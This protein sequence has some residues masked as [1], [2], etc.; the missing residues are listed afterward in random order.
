MRSPFDHDVG[1]LSIAHSKRS[2]LIKNVLIPIGSFLVAALGLL[3]KDTPAWVTSIVI[4]YLVFVVAITFVPVVWGVFEEW[5]C[6]RNTANAIKNNISELEKVVDKLSPQLSQSRSGAIFDVWQ[7]V[8]AEKDVKG[9][10]Y[11]DSLHL[12][13]LN[14]WF[15]LIR[16][17][18]NVVKK[19]DRVRLI[20]EFSSLVFQYARFCEQAYRDIESA[21]AVGTMDDKKV[22]KIKQEWNHARDSH[23]RLIE[24]WTDICAEINRL[25]G[26][27]ILSTYFPMLKPF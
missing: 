22:N 3:A 12:D 26:K 21:I 5:I 17:Y 16:D 24:N 9:V 13:T 7:N 18:V 10:I 27:E 8:A 20:K 6:R 4:L 15:R 14:T 19:R 1:E 2:S 23:N 25:S 11:A